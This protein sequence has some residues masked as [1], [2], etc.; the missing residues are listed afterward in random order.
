MPHQSIDELSAAA[1]AS[2]LS[3]LEYAESAVA[4]SAKARGGSLGSKVHGVKAASLSDAVVWAKQE[5]VSLA[6]GHADLMLSNAAINLASALEVEHPGS[7]AFFRLLTDSG[8]ISLG[9]AGAVAPEIQALIDE[10]LAPVEVEENVGWTVD[11]IYHEASRAL[12]CLSAASGDVHD[13][14]GDQFTGVLEVTAE[15]GEQTFA[16]REAAAA[17]EALLATT[18][19]EVRIVEGEAGGC[20]PAILDASTPDG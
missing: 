4:A 19:L 13:V 14:Q 10:S 1:E 17:L 9:F 15:E 18:N 2:G 11:E 3:P 5:G 20:E 12:D 8:S 16:D 7:L 6:E